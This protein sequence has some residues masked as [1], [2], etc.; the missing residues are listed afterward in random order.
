M[1]LVIDIG[2]TNTKLALFKDNELIKIFVFENFELG[3]LER[4]FDVHKV[5]KT[6]LSSVKKPQ[7]D[8]ITFLTNQGKWLKFDNTTPLPINIKYLTPETLGVDRI[9]AAVG[10]HMLYPNKPA[11]AID[12]GTCITYDF[13][14]K[15]GDYLGGGISPGLNMR[16]KALNEFTDRLPLVSPNNNFKLI[17]VSTQSSIVSGVQN[18]I[19]EEVKGVIKKYK[20]QYPG[21]QIVL[22]GGDAI[23]LANM[24]KNKIFA[25][26]ELVLIGL[27]KI[28]KYNAL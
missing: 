2:N 10:A 14:T 26:P 17:G 8:I 11:L 16:F 4:I 20:R 23:F 6:I 12:L 5:T 28:L 7:V 25:L 3:H 9:A 24:L 13:V 1:E 27:Q 18:G 22:S 15:E 21:V 19:V